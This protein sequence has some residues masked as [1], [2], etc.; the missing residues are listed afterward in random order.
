MPFG[1][2]KRA[3]A[4]AFVIILP[5]TIY[6]Y[7]S[8]MPPLSSIR[9]SNS[10]ILSSTSLPSH[11]RFRQGIAEAFAHHTKGNARIFILGRNKQ[12]A[13]T[14]LSGFPKPS[15]PEAKHQFLECDVSLMKNIQKATQELR[16][17][18]GVDKINY[19]VMSQGYFSVAG[20][21]ETEEGLDKKMAPK[22]EGG[23][24]KV[25]SVFSAGHGG[26]IDRED[27][28][29][30]KSYSVSKLAVQT[31]TYNDLMLEGFAARNPTLTFGHAYPGG[32]RTNLGNAKDSPLWMKASMKLALGLAY[33]FTVSVRDCGEYLLHGIVNTMNHPGAWRIT[34][35]GSD[36]GK[37]NYYGSDE[38]R[39][40]LWEHTV[41]VTKV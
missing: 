25:L 6:Y 3:L 19:L 21:T 20:Y 11:R 37:K 5:S 24:A 1:L 8:Q 38:D 27:L 14:I 35:D 7:K 13:E 30:K 40:A 12:A 17:K 32:V 10:A 9:A 22:K 33:P 23:D 39:K 36:L 4:A 34:N 28:G 29:F 16:E 18:H 15:S 41:Q 26:N 2:S 31:P